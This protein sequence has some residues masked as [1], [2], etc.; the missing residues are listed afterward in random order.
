[1]MTKVGFLAT[2]ILGANKYID[3]IFWGTYVHPS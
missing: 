3:P 2:W 1:M